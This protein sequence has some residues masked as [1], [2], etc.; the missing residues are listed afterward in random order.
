MPQ[1]AGLPKENIYTSIIIRKYQFQNCKLNQSAIQQKDD[2]FMYEWSLF[3]V[4]GSHVT[5]GE[6]KMQIFILLYLCG[7][8]NSSPPICSLS[9]WGCEKS[10]SYDNCF[11]SPVQLYNQKI[12]ETLNKPLNVLKLWLLVQI[13]FQTKFLFSMSC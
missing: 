5:P 10:S 11:R 12:K 4:K 9:P 13:Q 6:D 8:I 2:N 7:V 1:I 3:K